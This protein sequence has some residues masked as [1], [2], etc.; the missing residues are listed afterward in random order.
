MNIKLQTKDY[1]ILNPPF[2]FIRLEERRKEAK[3]KIE[4]NFDD[5]T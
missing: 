1:F 2:F 5:V 3:W 4:I